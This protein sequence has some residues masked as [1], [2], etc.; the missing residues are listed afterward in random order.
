M[1]NI[2]L[3]L[4]FENPI[5]PITY[6]LLVYVH[7]NLEKNSKMNV[8]LWVAKYAPIS[9]RSFLVTDMITQ[10]WFQ[11]LIIGKIRLRVTH[12]VRLLMDLLRESSLWWERASKEL[13]ILSMDLFTASTCED[14]HTEQQKL[15][16]RWYFHFQKFCLILS[17]SGS[18]TFTFSSFSVHCNQ[19]V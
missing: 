19:K 11:M 3:I 14:F 5:F 17:G 9:N 7:N 16:L 8:Y 10:L 6:Y 2:P 15:T 13:V 12:G 1:T 4:G 18:N